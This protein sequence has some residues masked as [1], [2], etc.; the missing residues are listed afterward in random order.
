MGSGLY[1]ALKSNLLRLLHDFK[2][3]QFFSFEG[4]TTVSR[5]KEIFPLQVFASKSHSFNL[6]NK[7]FCELFPDL[8]R[9]SRQLVQEQEAAAVRSKSSLGSA[10]GG[11]GGNSSARKQLEMNEREGAGGAA[12]MFQVLL[13]ITKWQIW[14]NVLTDMKHCLFV[15]V[16]FWSLTESLDSEA[17]LPCRPDTF[18]IC[19]LT[20][21]GWVILPHYWIFGS[22]L[23]MGFRQHWG[24]IL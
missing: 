11:G 15:W 23:V 24:K 14:L 6:T 8:V 10:A 4:R 1:S 19:H 21:K 3:R 5:E 13:T 18:R 16:T 17:K 7:H 20:Q 22:P 9:A 2:G 12:G